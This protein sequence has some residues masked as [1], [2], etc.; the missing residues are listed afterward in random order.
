MKSSFPELPSDSSNPPTV[1]GNDPRSTAHHTFHY[2]N[3]L[4][5][6]PKHFPGKK[7]LL[8]VTSQKKIV[9]IQ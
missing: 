4:W 8:T 6:H 5:T 1:Y 2:K 9:S 3:M 7:F